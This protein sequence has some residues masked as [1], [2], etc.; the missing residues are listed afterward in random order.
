MIYL[1]NAATTRPSDAAIAA[2]RESAELYANPASLHFFGVQ[3]ETALENARRTIAKSMGVDPECF[4]FTSGGTMSD[5]IAIRGYLQTKRKGRIITSAFEHPAVAECFKS[6]EGAFEVVYVKPENG[7]ITADAVANELTSDTVFVSVMQV[8]NE[9]GAKNDIVGITSML[10]EE[11]IPFHTDA[12]QGYMKETFIYSKVDMASFSAH[13]T[14]GPKGIGGLYVKK[15][16]RPKPMIYGGGQEGNI[17]SGTVNVPGAVAWAAAIEE[18]TATAEA[19][20]KRVEEVNLRYRE[21]I[22]ALGGRIITPERSSPYILSVAFEGYLGEN[23][24]HFLS[25]REIYLSTG[26][27]CSSKKVSP[28]M[29][30]IGQENLQKSVLR[31]SF[32][33]ENTLG[34][35]DVVASALAD[36]L[37]SVIKYN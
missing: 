18:Q 32:S 11:G 27:A 22:S 6:L 34:E 30:A 24:L 15:G 31:L 29:K 36:A 1:D 35:A 26:S 33:R 37:K 9:T 21:L 8:N 4:Y 3:A 2:M 19:D 28:V 12:V 14:H 25:E 10:R 20:R 5:N 23:I 13:K 7:I 17:H 16:L